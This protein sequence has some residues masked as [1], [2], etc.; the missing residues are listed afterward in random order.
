MDVNPEQSDWHRPPTVKTRA[1]MKRVFLR[2]KM[3]PMRPAMMEVTGQGRG[4]SNQLYKYACF[5]FMFLVL[6][7]CKSLRRVKTE[8]N[9][10]ISRM[11]T[12]VPSSY[13]VG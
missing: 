11:A 1:P 9:A 12:M 13:L 8:L 7:R 3:S 6:K 2:P 4:E 10:P 5:Y